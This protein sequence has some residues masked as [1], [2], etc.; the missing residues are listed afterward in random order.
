MQRLIKEGLAPGNG[1]SGIKLSNPYINWLITV[2]RDNTIVVW[3]LFDGKIMHSDIALNLLTKKSISR[4]LG[5]AS[6]SEDE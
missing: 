4:Q 6:E 1:K 3:K 5:S 2:S